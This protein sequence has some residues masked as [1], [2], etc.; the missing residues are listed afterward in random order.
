MTTTQ[1]PQTYTDH[2][3][4]ILPIAAG[5]FLATGAFTSLGTVASAQSG[6]EHGW[7]EFLV[8]CGIGLVATAVVFGL[9]VPRTRNGSRAGGVGLTLGI[10]AVPSVLAFWAGITP[11]LAVG[12]V[13]LGLAARREGRAGMGSAAVALGL[14]AGAGY[15]AIYVSDWVAQL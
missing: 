15:V 6:N 7:G 3:P 8:V 12:A 10:I 13:L 1:A 14:L 11:A 5:T 2:E 9:V 4:A